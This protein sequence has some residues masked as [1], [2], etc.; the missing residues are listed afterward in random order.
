MS[1]RLQ[2]I[3]ILSDGKPGHENQSVGLA[4]ALQRRTGASMEVIRFPAGAGFWEK[5]ALS[6]A[7]PESGV[8]PQ[9]VIGAGHGTHFSLLAA[10]R[11]FD[12]RSVV[13]MK[14]SLPAWFFDLCVVPRHDLKAGRV[15]GRHEF[16]TDGALNRV[17]EERPAKSDTGLILIGGPSAHHDWAGEPLLA[18]ISAI[19][20]RN[21]NLRWSLTD[22]RRT[23]PGF[24]EKVAALSMPS[25]TLFPHHETARGWLPAQLLSAQ[26]AW[27]T[28]DSISMIYES[29]TAG[30][31]TGLL[32][33]PAKN[34]RGRI[35]RAVD[36]VVE[37]G[38]ATRYASWA[39][40]ELIPKASISLH[41]AARCADE[42]LNRFFKTPR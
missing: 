6:C 17:S 35:A 29:I 12:A 8:R 42:I 39:D 11:R 27:V 15:A 24:M 38:F 34:P 14:P 41:E 26:E 33:L 32:A 4:E 5:R 31:R 13:V 21:P 19:V 36:G 2:A 30:A 7:S 20:R 37:K 1:H 40:S 25:L 18:A 23:P 10:A 16:I 9:L 28:E 3:R 22:S